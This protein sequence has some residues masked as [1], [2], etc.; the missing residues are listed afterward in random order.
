MKDP[1]LSQVQTFFPFQTDCIFPSLLI[2]RKQTE[3]V[4]SEQVL[5]HVF[6][7]CTK[8]FNS[9]VLVIRKKY[10]NNI[11]RVLSKLWDKVSGRVV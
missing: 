11:I 7:E 3:A 10:L 6:Q 4:M 8:D 9:S 1:L 2:L 5:E